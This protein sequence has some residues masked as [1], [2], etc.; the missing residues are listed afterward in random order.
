MIKRDIIRIIHHFRAL[1]TSTSRNQIAIDSKI[2]PY[3]CGE[4]G[5][6]NGPIRALPCDEAAVNS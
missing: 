4:D 5:V 6:E 1:F 2:F 3:I